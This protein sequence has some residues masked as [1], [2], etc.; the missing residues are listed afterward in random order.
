MWAL[1]KLQRSIYGAEE[2]LRCDERE[3]NAERAKTTREE[4]YAMERFDA[5]SRA[6][7]K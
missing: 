2:K 3:K 5:H 4:W 1:R 7:P 6:Q